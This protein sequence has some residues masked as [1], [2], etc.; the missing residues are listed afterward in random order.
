VSLQEREKIQLG[1]S[2]IE[3]KKP[4][5][6][7]QK[8]FRDTIRACLSRDLLTTERVQKFSARAKAYILAYLAVENQS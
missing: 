6:A 7:K 1:C 5:N 4:I 8:Q 2:K 3:S